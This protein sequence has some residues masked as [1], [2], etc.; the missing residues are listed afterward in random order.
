MD[1]ALKQQILI[2]VVAFNI[3]MTLDGIFILW[4]D[5]TILNLLMGV[6]VAAIFGAI[7]FF[8]AK[9]LQPK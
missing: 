2:G 4:G 6:V 5:F 9:L 3:V 1:E 7:A 8:A